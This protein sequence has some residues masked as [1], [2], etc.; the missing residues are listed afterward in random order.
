[1]TEDQDADR[2]RRLLDAASQLPRAVEPNPGAWREIRD[3]IEAQRVRALA[4]DQRAHNGAAA[5][6]TVWF[7]AAAALVLIVLSSGITALMLR[8]RVAP[9]V[10][11]LP[12]DP[13]RVPVESA[14]APLTAPRPRARAVARPPV[15]PVFSRYDAAAAD[16][17]SDMNARRSRLDPHTV[18]VLDSCL[19]RI[20]A[21]IAEARSALR[22]DPGNTIINALLTVHYEQKLDLLKRA[23]DL[24]LGS[25]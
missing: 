6:R 20:D 21:A 15:N 9:P 2:L 10:A 23:A 22:R 17:F 18:A 1:M 16:L 14:L 25:F 3:R 8:G 4:P 7:T 13:L 12:P 5:R 24:P 11:D 19:R